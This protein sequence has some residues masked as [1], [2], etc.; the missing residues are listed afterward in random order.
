MHYRTAAQGVLVMV[1]A[2]ALA[3]CGRKEA[4]QRS[5]D[6][7]QTPTSPPV[8]FYE[9]CN[10]GKQPQEVQ[11]LYQ[12]LM[13]T[14]QMTYEQWCDYGSSWFL[15]QRW[16]KAEA[17]YEAAVSATREPA[18]QAAALLLAAQSANM[19]KR[20]AEAGAMANRANALCPKGKEIGV[21]RFAFWSSAGDTLEKYIADDYLKQ[22]NLSMDGKAVCEPLTLCAIICTAAI[23]SGTGITIY[24]IHEKMLTREDVVAILSYTFGIAK[25][26]S[27]VVATATGGM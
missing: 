19:G 21:Y 24:A 5:Q 26:L 23:L 16:D 20:F 3:G 13:V 6:G 4:G 14:Q 22:V 10:N 2:V 27:T 18:K 7:K 25:S 8:V 1:V 12:T 17:A 15:E 11:H 9:S